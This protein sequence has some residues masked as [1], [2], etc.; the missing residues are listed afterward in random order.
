M[1]YSNWDFKGRARRALKPV[2]PIALLTALCAQLP[3]LLADTARTLTEN[4][5]NE[6]LY[7]IQSGSGMSTEQLL[8]TIAGALTKPYIAALVFTAVAALAGHCLTLGY[9]HFLL[10]TLRGQ[11]GDVSDVLSRL[12]IFFKAVGQELYMIVKILLWMVPALV[13]MTGMT[14]VAFMIPD[15]A[16]AVRILYASQAI[17]LVMALVPMIRAILHYA[18]AAFVMADHPEVGIRASVKESIRIMR[19]RKMQLFMLSFSFL[20]LL[21]LI[22]VAEMMLNAISPVIGMTLGMAASL[23]VSLY[24][25]MSYAAFYETYRDH[26]NDPAPE[27]PAEVPQ[28]E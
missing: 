5:M 14:A 18:M 19:S 27:E 10:K 16:T 13:V 26:S 28:D 7:A 12:P 11:E 2:F 1:M 3:G 24:M 4:P 23:G 20:G 6:A 21:L 15:V 8:A 9:Y 22:S 17:Y 25:N